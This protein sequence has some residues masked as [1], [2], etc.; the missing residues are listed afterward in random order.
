MCLKFVG[1]LY[2][3]LPD[4]HV[5]DFSFHLVKLNLERDIVLITFCKRII[6]KWQYKCGIYIYILKFMLYF[7]VIY[8]FVKHNVQAFDF[9]CKQRAW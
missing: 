6:V 8:D 4:M 9:V 3:T 2:C 7:N 1:I 5:M